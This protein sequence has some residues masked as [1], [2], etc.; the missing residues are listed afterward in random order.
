MKIAK[1]ILI[2][3][4]ITALFG[5]CFNPPDISDKPEIGFDEISLYLKDSQP[6]SLVVTITFKDGNGDLGLDAGDSTYISDPYHEKN[7]YIEKDG[8]LLPVASSFKYA[9]HPAV[10]KVPNDLKCS[11]C[12]L[13]T[14]RTRKKPEYANNTNLPPYAFPASCLNYFYTTLYID[15]DDA[16]IF[17]DTYNLKDQITIGGSKVYVLLDTFYYQ[18]N[19]NYY[20]IDVDFLVETTSGLFEVFDWRIQQGTC[21]SNFYGRFPVLSKQKTPLE[22]TLQYN[23]KSSGIVAL[24]GNKKRIKL[25]IT[26]RDRALHESNTITSGIFT[27]TDIVK[28]TG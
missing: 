14:V 20:N 8:D 25:R 19:P 7:Y 3:L 16:S 13:A 1:S 23:I 15:E 26:I 5:A 28:G 6:D 21:G 2:F 12:K 27:L 9:G 4:S 22:G 11:T 10:L 18:P 24:L 17:D